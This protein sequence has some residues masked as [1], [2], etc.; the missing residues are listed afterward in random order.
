MA[1]A[2]FG[3]QLTLSTRNQSAGRVFE[4]RYQLV[5]SLSTDD[6]FVVDQS[7]HFE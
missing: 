5:T 7:A 6:G 3:V 1:C 4:C 2:N